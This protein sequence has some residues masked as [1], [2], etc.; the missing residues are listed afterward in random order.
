MNSLPNGNPIMPKTFAAYVHP[1]EA[2]R[3][4]TAGSD[5]KAGLSSEEAKRVRIDIALSKVLSPEQKEQANAQVDEALRLTRQALAGDGKVDATEK[6]QMLKLAQHSL[7]LQPLG[8]AAPRIDLD[9]KAGGPSL[10][11]TQLRSQF[12]RM[13]AGTSYAPK[14]TSLQGGTK[15]SAGNPLTPHTLDKYLAQLKSGGQ[16]PSNYVAVALDPAL[17]KGPNAPF[18]YGDVLRIPEL[19]K[20]YNAAPIYFAIVDNG[21][22][23]RGTDGTKIDICCDSE[24]T[25]TVNQSLSLHSI[26]K[27]DG[28]RLNI[29]DLDER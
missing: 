23:F 1:L 3:H 26:S 20:A 7:E 6:Q 8:K 2:K 21:G 14:N 12:F 19:E 25:W 15:D 4:Y 24:R 22:A 13:A 11:P 29:R 28:S 10:D 27:P 17:Y 5:G 18:K 9:G 16:G